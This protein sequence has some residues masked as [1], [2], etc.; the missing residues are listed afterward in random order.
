MVGRPA[1]FLLVQKT[2]KWPRFRQNTFRIAFGD[3]F[4]CFATNFSISPLSIIWQIVSISFSVKATLC[5]LVIFSYLLASPIV[6]IGKRRSVT[7]VQTSLFFISQTSLWLTLSFSDTAFKFLGF[8]RSSIHMFL[9]NSSLRT[10]QGCRLPSNF[11]PSLTLSRALSSCV[12]QYKCDGLTQF[13][14]LQR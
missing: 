7:C 8:F 6:V 11:V 5:C 9:T 1:S 4:A 13:L 10:A 14:F 12:P 3:A 2:G